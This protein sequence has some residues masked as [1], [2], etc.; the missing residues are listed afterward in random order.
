[1]RIAPLPTD[2][3]VAVARI[4]VP[5]CDGSS[6]K[7]ARHASCGARARVDGR[8]RS[9][10]AGLIA[11]SL[12]VG[13]CYSSSAVP[14]GAL[15]R[16]HSGGKDGATVVYAEDGEPVRLDPNS[17]IRFT[18]VDGSTTR[19]F[20]V[21][22]LHVNDDGVFVLRDVPPEDLHSARVE[23]LL[24]ED[25]EALERTKPS[26]G[27]IQHVAADVLEIHGGEGSLVE[28]ISALRKSL[29]RVP[30]RWTFH[31][32]PDTGP[33]AGATLDVAAR[34]GVRVTDGLAWSSIEGTEVKN[35]HHGQTAIA[36]VAVTAVVIGL[37]A[38]V[39]ASKGKVDVGKIF[40]G[41]GRGAVE[42]T[43]VVGHIHVHG[44]GGSSSGD[45]SS[46]S[47]GASPEEE[48]STLGGAAVSPNADGARPLFGGVA[49]R[50]SIV[51]FVGALDGQRELSSLARTHVG[52]AAT[53]RFFDF[54]EVGGGMRWLADGAHARSDLLPF[55]RMGIHAGLDT[56]RR[57]A[58][59]FAFDFG[60]G[61]D[62]ALYL[63]LVW[64]LRVRVDEQWSIGFYAFNPTFARFRTSSGLVDVPRWSFPSGVEASF[65]F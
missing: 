50:R 49:R 58:L 34:D 28:W 44:G 2:L 4:M 15:G 51:R 37:V 1:M 10:V 6:E 39:S 48:S 45:V 3:R 18:R 36:I 47:S 64:G 14:P 31:L 43:R 59:P 60:G 35:L 5:G 33:Y 62:V 63:K 65:A 56:R 29:G 25:V 61:G 21:G 20:A 19:W 8:A 22:D 24:A 38:V 53:L 57:F 40:G 11:S 17:E 12:A 54:V 46:S 16:L 7:F 27:S 55:G 32:V 13:G 30:G 26:Y 41:L 23:G 52:F 42:G 9:F